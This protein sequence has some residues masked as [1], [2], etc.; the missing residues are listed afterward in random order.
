MHTYA[1]D[2]DKTPFVFAVI[3]VLSVVSAYLLYLFLKVTGLSDTLWF[4]DVP[5]VP[6][7]MLIYYKLFDRLLWKTEFA[8]AI[9]L[10]KTPNVGGSWAGHITSSHDA[11]THQIPVTLDIDQTASRISLVLDTEQSKSESCLAMIFTGSTGGAVIQYAYLNTPDN[12]AVETMHLHEGT[13]KLVLSS[14]GKSMTGN[15]Y[16]GRDR[17][18]RGSITLEK[19]DEDSI[20]ALDSD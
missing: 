13:T 3:A 15:Y 7:F 10:T 20:L 17:E 12:S 5:S 4:L 8:K 9:G 2:E 11:F 19:I 6:G 16:T 18:N 1:T 14:T